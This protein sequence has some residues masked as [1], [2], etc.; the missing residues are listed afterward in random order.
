[1][2]TSDLT[3]LVPA[4]GCK[5][6]NWYCCIFFNRPSHIKF[7]VENSVLEIHLQYFRHTDIGAISR[8]EDR[9]FNIRVAFQISYL[10]NEV[11]DPPIFLHF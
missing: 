9:F 11:G 3:S 6:G 5:R 10:R 8:K 7:G 1:M 4:T 2:L